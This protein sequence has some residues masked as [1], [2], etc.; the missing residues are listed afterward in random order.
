M[1]ILRELKLEPLALHPWETP[2]QSTR[3]H[4]NFGLRSCQRK[5]V[6][7]W[8]YSQNSKCSWERISAVVIGTDGL[9]SELGLEEEGSAS[10]GPRL[11]AV[12]S[13]ALNSLSG[14]VVI[15]GV[16]GTSL[17]GG[18]MMGEGEGIERPREEQV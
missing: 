12:N 16:Q 11:G 9:F 3:K 7:H 4:E 14:L 10:L 13:F 6:E 8:Q 17:V 1:R 15:A 2:L 18:D 5:D